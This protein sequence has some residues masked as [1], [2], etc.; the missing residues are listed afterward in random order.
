LKRFYVAAF[1][2]KRVFFNT[3]I[4]EGVEKQVEN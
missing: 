3:L 4:Q 2:V 1:F